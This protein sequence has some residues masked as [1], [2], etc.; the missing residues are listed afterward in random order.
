MSIQS[1][2][3]ARGWS[4]EDLA[5]HS[6]LSVRTIQRVESGRKAGLETLK[7]LAAVFETSVTEL[8]KEQ[9]MTAAAQTP[10]SEPAR[11]PETPEGLT[12]EEEDAIDYVDNLRAF[13]IHWIMYVFIIPALFLLNI[14]VSPG[15]MWFWYPAAAWAAV[16]GLHGVI[17]FGLFNIFDAS[18]EQR[19]FRKRMRNRDR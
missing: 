19:Q 15:F 5:L 9:D 4:Q 11:A 16:I 2:R 7:C 12:T 18:W 1:L 10:T 13:N 14:W 8:I 6:G 17:I 3:L